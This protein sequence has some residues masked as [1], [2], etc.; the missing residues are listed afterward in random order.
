MLMKLYSKSLSGSIQIPSSKS[1]CHRAIIAASL[2]E[3]ISKIQNITLSE[4][5]ECTL[6]AM[7][8]L[9]SH[10]EERKHIYYIQ[11]QKREVRA[12]KLDIFCSQSAS[13]LRFLIPLALVQEREARFFGEHNLPR[14]PLQ[15]YFPIF[16]KSKIIFEEAKKEIGLCLSVKGQLLAGDYSLPGNS[17]SQFITGLLFALPLLAGDS[18]LTI[19]NKLESKAYVDMTLDVLYRFGIEI[20]RDENMFFVPGGQRYISQNFS[21]EGDYSQAAFFLVANSLGSNI[22][23]RGLEE[24]SKQ[25]DKAILPFL[26]SLEEKQKG[27]F[28]ILDGSQCPDIIP[29]LS[30][31][32]ALTS[33]K[34]RI[35][36]IQRLRT[37]ECDRIHA[38][39][40]VL[41]RLGAKVI[42]RKD[43]L[44]FEG[45]PHLKGN[46][47]SSYGDHRMAMMI[48]I[49]S[50]RCQGDIL[51]DNADC[52][53][54]S[55][56]NF[57]QDFKS[58]GG[59]YHVG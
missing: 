26:K 45:V 41:N 48:A 1:F 20:I 31:R 52:V 29:V 39:S 38:T 59:E 11:K 46:S 49:A 5:I 2:A 50:I 30:L 58:L 6:D 14:R 28:L 57:W 21:I 10:I 17:S 44:E 53:K 55:Y 54:K 27:D 37:K 43:F 16:E 12:K 7:K 25:A 33:G 35:V 32:A 15:A 24:N 3:G 40:E 18:K 19:T 42:E 4:D 47:V 34:T 56:P 22:N 51:L 36:N 8:Q 13:T 9:G 23:I